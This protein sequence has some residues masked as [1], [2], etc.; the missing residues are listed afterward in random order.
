MGKLKENLEGRNLPLEIQAGQAGV[1]LLEAT[2]T[3][4]MLLRHKGFEAPKLRQYQRLRQCFPHRGTEQRLWPGHRS[5]G[6]L[7]VGG[8]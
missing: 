6:A 5:A 1:K 3:Q 2:R 4:K 7:T 8:A